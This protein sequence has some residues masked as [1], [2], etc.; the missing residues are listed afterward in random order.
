MNKKIR[1]DICKSPVKRE[2]TLYINGIRVYGVEPLFEPPV[3]SFVVEKDYIL[4][5]L[6]GISSY[7]LDKL[8]K[9]TVNLGDVCAWL[10]ENTNFSLED[11][12]NF[13]D[14][15]IKNKQNNIYKYE[16]K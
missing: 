11:I 15:M 12:D 8:Q 3:M 1:I 14:D 16:M 13:R 6:D 7:N 4:G 2:H 10:S 9:D 5:A